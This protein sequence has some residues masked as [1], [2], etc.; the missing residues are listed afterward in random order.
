MTLCGCGQCSST[1]LLVSR[2]A[3]LLWS[4]AMVWHRTYMPTTHRFLA[5]AVPRTSMHSDKISACS[6]AVASWMQSNRLQ[7]N[8]DKTEVLLWCATMRRQHQLPRSTLLVDGTLIN[9]VQSVHN[10]HQC[11]PGDAKPCAKDGF[12]VLHSPLAAAY[13]SSFSANDYVQDSYHLVDT[14]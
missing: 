5:H 3:W 14:V 9:P 1:C 7:L 2:M 10:F 12:Q 8:S 4:K 13:N 6:C 11:R